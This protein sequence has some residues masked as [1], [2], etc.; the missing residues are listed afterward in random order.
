MRPNI[1]HAHKILVFF[2]CL[3]ICRFLYWKNHN[4]QFSHNRFKY[5]ETSTNRKLFARMSAKTFVSWRLGMQI[6]SYDFSKI[7]DHLN[8]FLIHKKNWNSITFTSSKHQKPKFVLP[9]LP[10]VFEWYQKLHLTPHCFLDLNISNKQPIL[11]YR[12]SNFDFKFYWKILVGLEI[13]VTIWIWHIDKFYN[14]CLKVIIKLLFQISFSN[15]SLQ[16]WKTPSLPLVLEGF[17]WDYFDG[18][19]LSQNVNK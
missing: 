9:S 1:S 14:F 13:D 5:H 6:E 17:N 11:R 10:R 15:T 19:Y 8:Q 16:L 3:N 4:F 12:S 2:I 7:K 18:S